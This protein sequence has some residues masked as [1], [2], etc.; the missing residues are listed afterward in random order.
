LPDG[1]FSIKNTD[2]GKLLEGLANEVVI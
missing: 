1:I 2:L